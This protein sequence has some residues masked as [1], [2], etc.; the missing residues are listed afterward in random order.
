MNVL[1]VGLLQLYL[2]YFIFKQAQLTFT[3]MWRLTVNHTL[4]Y[5]FYQLF[6]VFHKDSNR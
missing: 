1:P 6:L 3:I 5:D 2:F 4:E